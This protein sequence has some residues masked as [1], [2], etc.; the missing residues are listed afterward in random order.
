MNGKDTPITLKYRNISLDR[1]ELKQKT[2]DIVLA[3]LYT[4]L[5]KKLEGEA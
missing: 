4:K 3:T 5:C 2:V 1:K